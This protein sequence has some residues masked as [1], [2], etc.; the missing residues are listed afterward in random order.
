MSCDRHTIAGPVRPCPT[1]FA[2]PGGGRNSRLDIDGSGP[3]SRSDITNLPLRAA[4]YPGG[5]S[6]AATGRRVLVIGLD[7]HRVPGPWDPEPVASAIEIGM[8]ELANH[9]VE[10]EACVVGLDGSEDIDARISAALLTR[11][12]DCVVVGGGIRKSEELLELFE[13]IVNLVRRHAPRA[14]IAFNS[15]PD[16]ILDAVVRRFRP[17]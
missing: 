5:V 15:S 8:A 7:P 9:G 13:S 4:A 3:S 14:E 17:G 10:A 2:R 11:R 16:D 6:S 12:W 1:S